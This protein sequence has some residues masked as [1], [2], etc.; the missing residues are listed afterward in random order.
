VE[1]GESIFEFFGQLNLWWQTICKI[2]VENTFCFIFMPC[3]A[4]MS[5]WGSNKENVTK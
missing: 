5:F 1:Q 3:Y 4:E 2:K